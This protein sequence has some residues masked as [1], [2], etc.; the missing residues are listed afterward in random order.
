MSTK[1]ILCLD[2]DGVLHSYIS[3]WQGAEQVPDAPVEGA[4]PFLESAINVFDIYVF[5]SRS[6]QPGGIS[7]MEE[8]CVA[9]FGPVITSR[10]SFPVRKP[11][12]LVTIDDRAIQFDGT[13]PD[14]T[15]LKA[16]QPW[17]KR[18]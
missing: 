12:A 10:L 11:P 3:G 9:H 18:K 6:G 14:V 13:W 8:W 1:P 7:A 15:E 5:S 4:G 17:N 2:F 16:F